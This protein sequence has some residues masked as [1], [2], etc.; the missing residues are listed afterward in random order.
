M[1]YV[2][3]WPRANGDCPAP[4]TTEASDIKEAV[5]NACSAHNVFYNKVAI[6]DETCHEL[7]IIEAKWP[8]PVLMLV[9]CHGTREVLWI[10]HHNGALPVASTFKGESQC[11][12]MKSKPT[13]SSKAMV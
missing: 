7:G 1:K 5:K 6:G 8:G 9:T 13:R 12:E 10:L 3:F 4:Y 11:Q 2:F